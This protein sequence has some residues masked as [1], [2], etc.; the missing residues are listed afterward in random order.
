MVKAKQNQKINLKLSVYMR[1]LHKEAGWRICDIAKRYPQFPRRTISWHANKDIEEEVCDK[2]HS[3]P[4][5]PQK[6]SERNIR[7]IVRTV[8]KSREDALFYSAKTARNTCGLEDQVSVRTVRRALNGAGYYYLKGRHKGVVT[9]DDRKCRVK[10]AMKITRLL[11]DNFWREG[12]SFYFDGVSFAHKLNPYAEATAPRTMMWRKRSEG[13]KFTCK[14]KKVGSGGAVAHFFVAV[15]YSKGV[16]MCEQYFE[17]LCG[18]MFN[19]FVCS[20]FP[21]AF[22]KSCNP[23]KNYSFKMVTHLRIAKKHT[24]PLMRLAAQCSRFQ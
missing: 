24:L 18:E 17:R 10:F 13:L 5:R 8:P 14:G 11:T 6:L 3:N 16:I 19:N 2:R 15:S 12:V 4:G 22:E 7:S 9:R 1:Y 20:K 21:E 23:K